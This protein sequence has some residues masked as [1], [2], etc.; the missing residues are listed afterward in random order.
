M[1]PSK[2]KT[3]TNENGDPNLTK[4]A[5]LVDAVLPVKINA[6]PAEEEVFASP[7]VSSDY[8]WMRIQD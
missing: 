3:T 1:A 5:N 8:S 7:Q 6:D 4:P 2:K